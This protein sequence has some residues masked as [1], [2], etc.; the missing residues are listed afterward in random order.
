M[1]PTGVTG[2]VRVGLTF[3]CRRVENSVEH[4]VDCHAEYDRPSTIAAIRDALES[5]GHEV[6]ELE[7][8][9]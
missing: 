8:K 3:N 5:L 6:V 1:K 2:K 7:A 9:A 4:Q